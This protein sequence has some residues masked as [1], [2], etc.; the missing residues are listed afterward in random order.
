M[1]ETTQI[2]SGTIAQSSRFCSFPD[3]LSRPGPAVENVP[4]FKAKPV[5]F[6]E[7]SFNSL[8]GRSFMNLVHHL[9]AFC[10]TSFAYPRQVSMGETIADISSGSLKK[11]GGASGFIEA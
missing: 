7:R 8:D 10:Q 2:T 9:H 3:M 6:D 5:K 4:R 11:N 1:A